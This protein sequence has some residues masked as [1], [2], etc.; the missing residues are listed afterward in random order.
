MQY[1]VVP[2]TVRENQGKRFVHIK[3]KPCSGRDDSRHTRNY[4]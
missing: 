1:E 4:K 3:S 2:Q